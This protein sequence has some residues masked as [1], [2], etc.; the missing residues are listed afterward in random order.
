MSTEFNTEVSKNTFSVFDEI[1]RKLKKKS[2]TPSEDSKPSE[3]ISKKDF[4]ARRL[5][6]YTK[7]VFEVHFRIMILS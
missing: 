5:F 2:S 4:I 3:R 6:Q 7:F 1:L